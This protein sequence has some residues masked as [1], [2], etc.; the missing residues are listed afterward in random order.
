MPRA[1]PRPFA[2]PLA[3]PVLAIL[4][5]IARADAPADSSTAAAA[6]TALVRAG[7]E[8]VSVEAGETLRVAYENRRFRHSAEA[9][10]LAAHRVG[11]GALFF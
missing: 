6:A 4:A 7:L 8:N 9:L 2:A 5:T 10:G 3:V 1:F 11:S